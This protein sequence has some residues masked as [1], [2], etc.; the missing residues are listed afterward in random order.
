MKRKPSL[1]KAFGTLVQIMSKP[2]NLLLVLLLCTCSQTWAAPPQKI[3]AVYAAT[4]NGLPFANVT[5]TFSQDH[6]HY[7]I[8]SVTDGIGIYGLFGK[9]KLSSNGEV[10]ADGLHP[11]HFEQMQGSKMVCS[12]EFDWTNHTLSMNAKGKIS[13]A[14]L[15]PGTLDLASYAYQF[16]FNPPTG[17]AVAITLTTGKKLRSYHYKIASHD[18]SL[19]TSTGV[20]KTTR[21]VNTSKDD[22]GEE[23]TLWLSQEQH[24]IPAK[25][26]MSDDSGAKIEQV[27][28]SLSIE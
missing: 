25:I 17:D 23:K 13:T 24:F 16:A 9:R 10:T 1:F 15:E 3:T 20:L 4:R 26:I 2:F 22:N 27:L 6:G 14:S 28:T 18:E 7:Q 21:L 12:A 8:E 5:E 11:L 19:E